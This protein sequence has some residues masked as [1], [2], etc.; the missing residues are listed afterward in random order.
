MALTTNKVSNATCLQLL[1]GRVVVVVGWCGRGGK[2]SHIFHH[3]SP[4]TYHLSLVSLCTCIAVQVI[5]CRLGTWALGIGRH[6][7][8]RY[9]VIP[10]QNRIPKLPVCTNPPLNLYRP[11]S[12]RHQRLYSKNMKRESVNRMKDEPS[13]STTNLQFTGIRR[14]R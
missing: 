9:P 6:W 8:V 12:L 11:G 10:V 2:L 3:I 14:Q 1:V 4:I 13:S 7:A 5:L